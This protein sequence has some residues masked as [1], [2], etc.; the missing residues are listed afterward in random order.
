LESGELVAAIGTLSALI[1]SLSAGAVQWGLRAAAKRKAMA[2]AA[3]AEV[4]VS[5]TLFGEW[6]KIVENLREEVR[7]LT[8][9]RAEDEIRL[10]AAEGR[11]RELENE[12]RQARA[13]ILELKATVRALK[14]RAER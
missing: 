2:E 5:A 13:D 7:R 14:A 3:G 10:K 4:G 8:A 12:L 6:Q 11:E 9:G 1:G